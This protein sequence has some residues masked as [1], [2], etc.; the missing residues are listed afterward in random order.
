MH[1]RYFHVV[2]MSIRVYVL[3]QPF[4]A[5]FVWYF[6]V[7]FWDCGWQLVGMMVSACPIAHILSWWACFGVSYTKMSL[8]KT[9]CVWSWNLWTDGDGVSHDIAIFGMWCRAWCCI[10][11]CL[12]YIHSHVRN[13]DLHSYCCFLIIHYFMCMNHVE[14]KQLS[15]Q[16]YFCSYLPMHMFDIMKGKHYMSPWHAFNAG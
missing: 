1:A 14:S 11:H 16:V 5:V 9:N 3:M 7:Y 12:Q 15:A 4:Y 6:K 2:Y 10:I 13:A 8:W